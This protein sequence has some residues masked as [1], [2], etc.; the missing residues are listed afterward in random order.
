M[1]EFDYSD[2]QDDPQEK[3]GDNSLARLQGLAQE[4]VDCEARVA[5][6]EQQLEEAKTALNDVKLK[7]LP[8]LMDELEMT[9]FKTAGGVVISMAE[10]IRASIPKGREPEAHKW[11]EDNDNG[12]L[13]KRQVT[14]DFAKSE[15]AW[16][17]KFMADCAKRKKPLNLAMKKTVHASTLKAFVKGQLEE[18]VDIP[19]DVFGV[20]RQRF[21]KV[22]LPKE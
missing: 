20:F 11:L 8:D 9:E 18:G 14:I 10:E 4:Q 2:Y 16:A 3:L 22:K 21:A 1:A 6:L 15:E 13:I 19:Q 7:R 5:A 17:K 12:G